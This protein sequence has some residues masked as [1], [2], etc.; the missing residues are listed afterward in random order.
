MKLPSKSYTSEH[1]NLVFPR[2]W[3][4]NLIVH[5]SINLVSLSLLILYLSERQR[6]VFHFNLHFVNYE[7]GSASFQVYPLFSFS[8]NL[9]L[10]PTF[11]FLWRCWVLLL[12]YENCLYIEAHTKLKWPLHLSPSLD[13]A[14]LEEKEGIHSLYNR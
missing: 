4:I 11:F 12:I 14:L 5:G 10:L 3:I 9:Y 2:L 6:I 13:C 7:L 8:V 1:S